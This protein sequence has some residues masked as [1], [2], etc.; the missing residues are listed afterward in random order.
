MTERHDSDPT[1]EDLHSG[2]PGPLHKRFTA[3]LHHEAGPGGWP[4][5]CGWARCG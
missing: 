4:A 2:Q 1:A 3:A 5:P